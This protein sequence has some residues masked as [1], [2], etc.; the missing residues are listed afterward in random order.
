[1]PGMVG[2]NA[3]DGDLSIHDSGEK[4]PDGSSHRTKS[5]SN[6]INRILAREYHSKLCRAAD[7]KW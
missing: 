1:M 7:S 3:S 2:D 4:G 5:T 6:H